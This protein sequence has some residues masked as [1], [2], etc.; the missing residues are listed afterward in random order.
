ALRT[1]GLT[2]GDRVALVMPM[3]PEVVTILYACFKLGLIV[4]PIFA[5]F[6][7]GAIATRLENSGA[8]VVFTADCAERRGKLLPLKEKVDQALERPTSV[9]KVI[10]Y[11]YKGGN[12]GW[13][14]ERGLWWDDFV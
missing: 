13:R 3:I 10:V 12:V 7:A 6:G 8:R 1:L 11:R 14:D 5:G 9:E 2:K 4:V